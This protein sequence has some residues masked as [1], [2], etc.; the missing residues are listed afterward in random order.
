M[1]YWNNLYKNKLGDSKTTY[2]SSS[3]YVFCKP[4]IKPNKKIIEFGC[5]NG[6][7]AVQLTKDSKEYIGIDLCKIAIQICRELNLKNSS[8]IQETF[9]GHSLLNHKEKLSNADIIFSRFS[10]HSINLDECKKALENANILLNTGGILLIETRSINDPRYG[11]GIKVKNEKHAFIDTHYRRFMEVKELMDLLKDNFNIIMMN[12][13]YVDA[14]YHDDH[15]VVIR[16][17]AMKK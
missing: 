7:D 13:E 11:K 6:K 16:V 9:G 15:A 2:N 3:F 8:F 12:E 10:L 1:E 5:G 4:F 17:I 14:N